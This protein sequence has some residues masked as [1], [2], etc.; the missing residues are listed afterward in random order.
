MEF[1]SVAWALGSMG[2]GGQQGTGGFAAFVPLILMGVI[3]YFL[4][5]RPQQRKQKDLRNMLAAIKKGD[6]VITQGGL[7][8]KVTGVTDNILTLEIAEKVRVRVQRNY[9]AAVTEK[10]G[11]D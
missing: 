5:I 1:V 11:G 8:G 9:V 6:T 2:Q 3:F 7:Y 4:L 10:G